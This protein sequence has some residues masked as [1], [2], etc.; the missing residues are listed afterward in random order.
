MPHPN[1]RH[2]LFH[3]Q[4]N[5]S[6]STAV[7]V[8]RMSSS[9]SS[10]SA[11]LSGTATPTINPPHPLEG[12]CTLQGASLRLT[13]LLRPAKPYVNF[14]SLMEQHGIPKAHLICFQASYDSVFEKDMKMSQFLSCVIWLVEEHGLRLFQHLPFGGLLRASLSCPMKCH[15]D[16]CFIL[17][18]NDESLLKRLRGDNPWATVSTVKEAAKN[19]LQALEKTAKNPESS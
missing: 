2:V 6:R 3:L 4:K 16:S 9:A 5:A 8:S 12:S 13:R 18:D 19:A 11:S 17:E 7:C 1:T 15:R 14:Q 10:A